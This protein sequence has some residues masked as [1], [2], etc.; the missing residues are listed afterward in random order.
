MRD[1]LRPRTLVPIAHSQHI[2]A[3][4]DL[5][6]YGDWS[7]AVPARTP[8]SP[9]FF[10]SSLF[11]LSLRARRAGD[12]T[13]EQSCPADIHVHPSGKFVYGSNRGHDSIAV[14]SVGA[15]GTLTAVGHTLTGGFTPRNFLV[16]SSTRLLVANQNAGAVAGG[17]GGGNVVAFDIDEAT[18]ALTP[19]GAVSEMKWPVRPK[20]KRA[21]WPLQRA[22][23]NTMG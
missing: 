18:G 13:G 19:T 9:P 23:L 2:T 16:S 14:Y 7:R 3:C 11:S 6:S 5:P 15:D 17:S 1:T 22:L 12:F 21:S 4:L 10:L 20:K 8:S